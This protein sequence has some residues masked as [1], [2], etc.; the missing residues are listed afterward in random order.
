MVDFQ[1]EYQPV[2][3]LWCWSI[4]PVY[5]CA[6]KGFLGISNIKS[7]QVVE[8]VC[9]LNAVH[10]YSIFSLKLFVSQSLV[11]LYAIVMGFLGL[12]IIK[13]V[14]VRSMLYVA[15]VMYSVTYSNRVW[16]VHAIFK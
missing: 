1:N 5:L 16:G 13:S 8:F 12:S 7:S 14:R 4:Q 15:Y 11:Y 9:F 10:V 3:L 2:V 6:M